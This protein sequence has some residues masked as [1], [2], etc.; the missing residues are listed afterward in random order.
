[1]PRDDSQFPRE[2]HHGQNTHKGRSVR[3]QSIA[4]EITRDLKALGRG[5]RQGHRPSSQR[6][7]GVYT[8]D[9]RQIVRDYRKRLASQ[10]GE[11]VY[12]VA[13]KLLG[14]NV[15][16][17]R[18]VAYELIAG[19][20]L[21]R[22]SLTP[23]KLEALGRGID[24]WA[25]VDSFC[26]T[27]VGAAW[28]ENRVSDATIK[29]W[30]RS[31]DL[32]WRRAAVVSTVPL[33]IKSHGG[34]GDTERTLMICGALVKDNEVMVQKAISWALRAL[35]SWD[36]I[37]VRAFLAAHAESLSA[38]VRREVANKLRTGRKN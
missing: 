13:L 12:E 2:R 36:P 27:L 15:T 25:S 31:D 11:F 24:N 1:M 8:P 23:K 4:D 6:D 21:A 33:N 18:Q 29:R 34:T 38:L 5:S 9:L 16:E 37:S 26:C 10:S 3:T 32:W 35:A 19:H 22:E 17:C 30:S 7:F 28:K 14:K 20:R